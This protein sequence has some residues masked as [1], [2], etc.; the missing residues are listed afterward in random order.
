MSMEKFENLAPGRLAIRLEEGLRGHHPLFEPG[1]IREAFETEDRPV[2]RADA[3]AVGAALLAICES[4][5]E[6]A[7]FAVDGLAPGA[8]L[9][10][11]RL[12][13]RLLDRAQEDRGERH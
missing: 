9:S 3:D 2:T 12:Y 11:I 10:L 7:R 4:P 5:L 8:R 13:F 6:A 1:E